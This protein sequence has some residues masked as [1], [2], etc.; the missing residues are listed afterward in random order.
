MLLCILYVVFFCN[1]DYLQTSNL[2]EIHKNGIVRINKDI[3][4]SHVAII[5]FL[6]MDKSIQ[7]Q[8]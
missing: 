6:I 5:L 1:D 4:V 8:Q 2:Q 3:N 7:R